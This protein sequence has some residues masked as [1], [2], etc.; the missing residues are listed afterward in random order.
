MK[1]RALAQWI[2]KYIYTYIKLESYEPCYVL[3]KHIKL[4]Y[5]ITWK[6]DHMP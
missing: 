4:S 1:D 3:A 2:V 5:E 6:A